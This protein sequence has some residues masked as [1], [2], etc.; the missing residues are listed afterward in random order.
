MALAART[1]TLFP[2]DRHR[3]AMA[4]RASRRSHRDARRPALQHA[5]PSLAL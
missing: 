3:P 1:A 5:R 2:V 4:P